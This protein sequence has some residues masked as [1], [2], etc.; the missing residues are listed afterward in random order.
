MVLWYYIPVTKYLRPKKEKKRKN[1]MSYVSITLC[2]K[3]I[4]HAENSMFIKLG[5]RE[6]K[7]NQLHP[8]TKNT[9]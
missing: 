5:H 9:N 7:A 3:S 1:D 8:L 4:F 2:L 6:F